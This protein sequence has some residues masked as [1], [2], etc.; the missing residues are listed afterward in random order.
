MDEAATPLGVSGEGRRLRKQVGELGGRYA[1]GLPPEF[2][3]WLVWRGP[4][5]VHLPP[6]QELHRTLR[7]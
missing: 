2:L 4:E 1:W 6:S 7:R 3:L 5:N